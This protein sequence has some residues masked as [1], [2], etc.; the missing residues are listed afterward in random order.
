MQSHGLAH[1]RDPQHPPARLRH[2]DHPRHV[3][4]RRSRRPCVRNLRR[5]CHHTH[6]PSGMRHHRRIAPND[7]QVQPPLKSHH[8][9]G[10]APQPLAQCIPIN[11]HART[12]TPQHRPSRVQ[13]NVS[14]FRPLP[15]PGRNPHRH[16]CRHYRDQHNGGQK[17]SREAP[18]RAGGDG[19]AGCRRQKI[20]IHL[21]PKDQNRAAHHSTTSCGNLL[22]QQEIREG[23]VDA[24]HGAASV[25]F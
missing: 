15:P 12:A 24:D 1:S 13:L 10:I 20:T 11:R 2:R 4:P 6:R 3:L 19:G 22:G 17:P 9:R 21:P 8:G 14:G 16:S 25:R 7:P 18:T 23:I 5:N